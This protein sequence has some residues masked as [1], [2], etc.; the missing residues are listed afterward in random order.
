M[1]GTKE[2]I[3]DKALELFN[4][5]GIEYVGMRE[6]AAALGMRIG[7]IT[8]Y[9]PTKDD[10]VFAISQAYSELNTETHNNFK[11]AS[12]YDF[13]S[14][15]KRLFENGVQYRSLMLSMVH[16]MEQN[17][18][19]SENYNKVA[20]VRIGGL[21]AIVNILKDGKHIT[22]EDE[23][24]EWFLVSV[25]SLISRFWFSE[26]ALTTRRDKLDTYIG[27]YLKLR[28]MLFKPYA[29]KKGLKDIERFM[30]EH[31]LV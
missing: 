4:E 25:N 20:K 30:Q 28:A 14:K 2:K 26:A 22:V 9:F 29:T 17:P 7:N 15:C 18:R 21:T 12:L 16:I 6:L 27:R 1:T 8:Y 19:I 13:L 23:D 10:L 5:K 31:K 11:V 24:V 3:L